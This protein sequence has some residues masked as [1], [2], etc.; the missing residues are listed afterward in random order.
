MI[1]VI[2]VQIRITI[3][4]EQYALKMTIV[5]IKHGAELALILLNMLKSD[6]ICCKA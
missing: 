6:K 5:C 1:I 2:K 4:A 3:M